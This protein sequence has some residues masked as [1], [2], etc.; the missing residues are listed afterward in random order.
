MRDFQHDNVGE[1]QSANPETDAL[2][3]KNA[4]FTVHDPSCKDAPFQG[5]GLNWCQ[6]D[7]HEDWFLHDEQTGERLISSGYSYHYAMDV[8]DPGFRQAWTDSVLERLRDTG[9]AG[10]FIDDATLYPVHWSPGD[11]AEMS[12]AQ[13]RD[14]MRDFISYVGQRLRQEGFIVMPNVSLQTDDGAQRAAMLEIAR[15]VDVVNR[16]YYVRWGSGSALFTGN[17]WKLHLSLLE[18][19][20]ATG[21]G[22]N[23]IAF[24]TAADIQGQ[25]YAR[26]TFLMGWDGEDGSSMMFRPDES[27]DAYLPDW[28]TDVGVPLGP[29][30]AVGAGWKR[31]FSGG[32]VVINPSASGSQ[33]FSLGGSYRLPSGSCVSSV[34]LAA[35]RALVLPAC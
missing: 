14:A 28:T 34:S 27:T 25:R 8:A 23:G 7:S 6:A 31:E 16:E 26:A 24:G 22:Y 12:D 35:T 21:A 2:V 4:A 32:I 29:R 1:F 11:V 19:I 20:L 18:E 15:N 30:S 10:V 17:D 3:Y 9:Y 13:Y 33:S 5:S